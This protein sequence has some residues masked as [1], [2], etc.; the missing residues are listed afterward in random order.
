MKLTVDLRI[1]VEESCVKGDESP[2][3][4]PLDSEHDIVLFVKGEEHQNPYSFTIRH[5]PGMPF[6]SL[7][8]DPRH[9]LLQYEGTY[10]VKSHE[11][12]VDLAAKINARAG[13]AAGHSLKVF[14][15][16]LPVKSILKPSTLFV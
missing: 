13:R 12:P 11:R 4:E 6:L 3:S 8:Y 10:T 2:F 14:S 5:S 16:S 15:S 1:F 7:V 9:G